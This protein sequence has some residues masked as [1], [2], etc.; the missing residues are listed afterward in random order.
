MNETNYDNSHMQEEYMMEDVGM[1]FSCNS[2]DKS[3]IIMIE[4][5]EE[6]KD[7]MLLEKFEKNVGDFT[8]EEVRKLRF[9]SLELC[10]EF[11]KFF[12]KIKGFGVRE[13]GS[14]KSRIDGHPT[15]RIYKCPAEGLRE[16][17]HVQNAER[18]R[19]A[20]PLLS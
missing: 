6:L 10:G 5:V 19:V 16:Q 12:A 18:V 15:S 1:Y 9:K 3:D 11:T 4:N 20:K 2:D 8:I 17:K 7:P 14:R 13:N